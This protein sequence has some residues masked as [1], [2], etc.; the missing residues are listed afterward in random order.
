MKAQ[1]SGSAEDALLAA[2]SI[3]SCQSM[4][5][6]GQKIREALVRSGKSLHPD[7]AN[8]LA[9]S[10]DLQERACQE[11][12]A[13]ML[14]EYEPMLRR[15][16]EGGLKGAAALWWLTPEARALSSAASAAKARELLRRDVL[17]CDK[18]SFMTYQVISMRFSDDFDAVEAAAVRA[19][20]EEL[21]KQGKFKGQRRFDEFIKAFPIPS[22]ALR[23]ALNKD[24]VKAKTAEIL[25]FCN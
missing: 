22:H 25:S 8:A 14:A 18:R 24:A 16:L 12:D 2:N 13:S 3:R 15:A 20:A 9:T 17:A 6:A 7:S 4:A 5:G 23:A 19:A 21:E 10:I 1:Q 11:L